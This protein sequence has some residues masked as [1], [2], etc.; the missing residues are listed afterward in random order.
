M[1]VRAE[2]GLAPDRIWALPEGY[3]SRYFLDNN[4]RENAFAELD[5][6]TQR[7]YSCFWLVLM[8]SLCPG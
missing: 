7:P 8:I 3:S 4:Y 5:D 2:F 6:T 1:D